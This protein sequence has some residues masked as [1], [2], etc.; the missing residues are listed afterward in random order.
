MPQTN[1]LSDASG[2]RLEEL[3]KHGLVQ[4]DDVYKSTTNQSS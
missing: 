2:G 3:A 1:K 4:S